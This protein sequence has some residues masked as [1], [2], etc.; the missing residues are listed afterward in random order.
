M[1]G[2]AHSSAITHGI[3]GMNAFTDR[4][5]V[6][7]FAKH[8][9]YAR[10]S[11]RAQG[12]AIH[13]ELQGTDMEVDVQVDGIRAKG[14]IDTGARRTIANSALMRAL[15]VRTDD[16]PETEPI[17]GATKDKMPARLARVKSLRMG[18]VG[19]PEPSLVVADLLVFE[20]RGLANAPALVLG[21]DLLSKLKVMTVDYPRSELGIQP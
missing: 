20:R 18:S 4:Q 17:E 10:H 3:L 15:S 21:I 6:F 2:L 1:V 13:G 7:D 9:L 16:L 12:E 5:I 11:Q 19:F 14:L 8:S